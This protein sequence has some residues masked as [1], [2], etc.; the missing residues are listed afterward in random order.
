MTFKSSSHKFT[1]PI[2]VFKANDPYH[3]VVDNLP[4]QQLMENDRWLKDQIDSGIT[5]ESGTRA[6]FQELKPYAN[7]SDNVIHVNPGQYHARINDAYGKTR[8]QSLKLLNWIPGVGKYYDN[9]T[10]FPYAS[11]KEIIRRIRSN[12]AGDALFLNG[13][14]EQTSFWQPDYPEGSTL[15]TAYNANANTN[16]STGPGSYDLPLY[17]KVNYTPLII[18]QLLEPSVLQKL[19]TELVRMYRGVG[20]LAVVS[21]DEEL[22]LEVPAYDP[23]D[24]KV[25]NSDT[26][27]D[28]LIDA[29]YRIDLVFIYSHPIDASSTT[30]AKYPGATYEPQTI[31][32]PILGLVKGAG[33]FTIKESNTP[34]NP[35]HYVISES[36]PSEPFE[37]LAS[38]ADQQNTN[39]GF[40][41]LGIHGSF[42]SPEDLMNM[43]PNIVENLESDNIQLVGQSVFPVCYVVVRKNATINVGGQPVIAP[44][45]VIDIRP[46]FR[47]A[48]LTYN[49]RA[50]ILMATPPISPANSV[51]GTAQLDRELRDLYDKVIQTVNTGSGGSQDLKPRVVAGGTIW[52]GRKFGPEGAIRLAAKELNGIGDSALPFSEAPVLPDW[53]YAEYW[54]MNPPTGS[55]TDKGQR[56]NDYINTYL[57]NQNRQFDSGT[58]GNSISSAEKRLGTGVYVNGSTLTWGMHWCKKEIIIDKAAV[59]WMNDYTVECQFENCI[60]QTKK[61]SESGNQYNLDDGSSAGI[62]VE[63]KS[64]RFIIYVAW[65]AVT[66]RTNNAVIAIGQ[67][68]EPRLNRDSYGYSGF[69]VRNSDMGLPTGSTNNMS[70]SNFLGGA[71]TTK[72]PYMGVCTYPTVSFKVTAYPTTYF[73]KTLA[74]GTSQSVITL[75]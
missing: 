59:P 73:F 43:A 75:K 61:S 35:T 27:E 70:I 5:D 14:T 55:T 49:E 57:L 37:I 8:M 38:V 24:F 10:D 52:G 9:T 44:S 1:D 41:S 16:I 28:E 58:N 36:A 42:P 33:L 13:L 2:R 68:F 34:G 69:V 47:T 25:R 67:G 20:R 17:A 54:T 64:D 19:S 48:E 7:G 31:N 32:K 45:D 46:F 4:L 51:V 62:W 40:K 11:L 60:P 50:G 39:N 56:R 6:G 74:Q 15:E 18:N 63:K 3:Y 66:P 53:D 22:T 30:I 12:V 71:A 23:N 21:V 26:G 65:S 29:D 72:A